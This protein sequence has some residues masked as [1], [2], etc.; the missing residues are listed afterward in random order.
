MENLNIPSYDYKLRKVDEK[1]YI[2]DILRRKYI[3][4]TPEEWVRQHFV[5]FLIN[6]YHYPKSLIKLESS[7]KYNTLLKRTD[8]QVFGRDGKLKM[9]IECKAPYIPLSQ[10]VFSQVAEYNQVLKAEFLTITNGMVYHCCKTDWE[11]MN[12]EFLKDLPLFV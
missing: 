10:Q 12:L 4:L 8:I 11:N 9:I 7:L 2:Y 3:M 5:H 6:H 1:I